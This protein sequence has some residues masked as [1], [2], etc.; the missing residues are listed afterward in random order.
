MVQP[1]DL[2]IVVIDVQPGFLDGWMTGSSEPVLARVGPLWPGDR[3]RSAAAG[4]LRATRRAEGLAAGT[5]GAVS[6]AHGQRHTKRTFNCCREPSILTAIGGL[7]RAQIAVAGRETDVCVLQ[8]VLGL[9]A[10]G[11]QVFLLEDALFS[12][13]P[14]VGP[15]IRRME[16]AGA[17]PSTVRPSITSCV[18]RWLR[19]GRRRSFRDECRG[20]RC[21]N[22]RTCRCGSPSDPVAIARRPARTSLPVDWSLCTRSE[23]PS[24]ARPRRAKTCASC[25][26]LGADS[27]SPHVSRV[28]AGP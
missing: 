12:S 5:P 6:P 9:I 15:A 10:A 17:I 20:C 7:G 14:N 18:A 13:E 25:T 16:S 2:A 22:P 27:S 26:R 19:S 24:R 11:K 3:L 8:S 4:H 23:M 21:P 1:D 28:G